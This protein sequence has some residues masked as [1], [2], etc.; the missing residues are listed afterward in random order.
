MRQWTSRNVS[1]L[2]RKAI[3]EAMADE[4]RRRRESMA[5]VGRAMLADLDAWNEVPQEEVRGGNPEGL[6]I[7]RLPPETPRVTR[8]PNAPEEA[9]A[10]DMPNRNEMTKTQQL[11]ESFF[12]A[13]P[14]T[15]TMESIRYLEEV[16]RTNLTEAV[17]FGYMAA[18]HPLTEWELI[19]AFSRAL[20]EYKVYLPSPVS[21]ANTVAAS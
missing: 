4:A 21:S 8:N 2:D 15:A 17:R 9:H 20:E 6:P 13:N 7:G 19:V 18:L 16:F 10:M 1:A 5:E 3:L 11:F 14:R 12:P